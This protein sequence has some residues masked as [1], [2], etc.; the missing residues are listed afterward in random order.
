MKILSW[1]IRHSDEASAVWKYV[2]DADPDIALLQEV[3][4]FPKTVQGRFHVLARPAAKNDGSPQK[5]C[6][7]VITKFEIDGA[8]TLQSDRQWVNEQGAFFKGNLVGATL[9]DSDQQPIHVVS[10]YSPHWAVAKEKW[11]GV[12]VTGLKLA[13]NPDIWCTEILW[14]LLRNTMPLQG[15]QWIVGGDFNSS[16]TFDYRREGDRGN[17]EIMRRMT[18]LGLK[19]ML[20][21]YKGELV[22]T[23][24]QSRGS[25]RGML[26]HQLDHLY[27]SAPLSDRLVSC[28]TADRE[29]VFGSRMSDHLPVIANFRDAA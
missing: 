10:V 16:K 14:D 1:N 15:G 28:Q 3:G 12:D 13:A 20:R 4:R 29:R 27:I 7:A 8:L 19:E 5:F 18:G 25:E 21:A 11:A 9:R 17:R 22:P 24:K 2:L 26:V 23:F 6:T